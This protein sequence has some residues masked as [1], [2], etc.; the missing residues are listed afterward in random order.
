MSPTQKKKLELNYTELG[1]I[2]LKTQP[3]QRF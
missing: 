1:L 2:I 3:E